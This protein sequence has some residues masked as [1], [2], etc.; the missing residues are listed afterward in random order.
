MP[1]V[2]VGI[3]HENAPLDLVEKVTLSDEDIGKLLVSVAQND[4][5]YE[6]I[7]LSTCLRTEIYAVTGQFHD[8]VD[9]LAR[10]LSSHTGTSNE[11]LEQYLEVR[12]DDDA[13]MYIFEVAA[14]LR[15]SIPGETEVLGQVKRALEHAGKA[16]SAG[17]VL[18][19][20]FQHAIKAGKQVR[21]LTGIARGPTS[22]A[23]IAAEVVVNGMHGNLDNSKVVVIGA[24]E[25]GEGLAGA[26]CSYGSPQDLAIFSRTPQKARALAGALVG[27]NAH[28]HGMES[29]PRHLVG[30]DAVMV[31]VAARSVVLDHAMVEAAVE[32]ARIPSRDT[33][34]KVATSSRD[35]SGKGGDSHAA[36]DGTVDL[37]IVDLGMPKNVDPRVASIDGVS[38]FDMDYMVARAE[39]TLAGRREEFDR[40]GAIISSGIESY[41]RYQRERGAV[42]VLAALRNKVEELR[43]E[44][45]NNARSRIIQDGKISDQAWDEMDRITRRITAKMLHQPTIVLKG[46]AG[47]PKGEKIIE[48]VRDLFGL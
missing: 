27:V 2:V 8:A 20:L 3:N 26:I 23:H 10:S 46:T 48:A 31:S 35:T 29:L 40:A 30:A 18:N 5:L 17:P 7:V 24:G 22:F 12:F 19:S 41:R 32:K 39:S 4:D 28:G 6:A 11:L 21:N 25:M 16:G 36:P 15:S 38:L 1:I 14:G 33:S 47:T 13:V 45:L 44:E 9:D 42:P 43:V 37:V 34:G